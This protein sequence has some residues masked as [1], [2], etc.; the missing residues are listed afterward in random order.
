MLRKR[1]I[2][3]AVL[4]GLLIFCLTG[5]TTRYDRQDIGDYVKETIGLSEIAISETYRAQKGE[6]TYTDK[7][8][9]VKD[10]DSGLVFHVIDD[11]YWGMETMRNRLVSDYN[12]SVVHFL[13][14]QLPDCTRLSFVLSSKN[15]IFEAE[16]NGTFTNEEELQICF[17]ELEY[18]Q[19]FF[20]D[21]GYP[22]LSVTY[23]LLYDHPLNAQISDYRIQGD[24]FGKTGEIL[25]FDKMFEEYLVSVLD[26]RY[27]DAVN[28][29]PA[30]KTEAF[31]ADCTHKVGICRADGSWTYYGDLIASPYNYGISFGTLYEI[32]LREG[33]APQ[34]T[35][36]HYRF[37]GIDGSLYEISY[38]FCD[39]L[40][41]Q[42]DG[43]IENGYYYLK[44][45]ETIPMDY[46]F[47]N[48]LEV[49]Q[50][51]EMTGLQLTDSSPVL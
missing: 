46:Y 15:G 13:K 26:F 36:R 43:T 25:D 20:S 47:Y 7:I 34:G 3:T 41:E 23:Q 27:D 32:L 5:C 31:L 50:I 6:D 38:D 39:Y 40:F 42:S 11:F 1:K 51:Q 12:E 22:G 9:T 8:W 14:K 2:L 28:S 30:E 29:L 48:H 4:S 21:A 16:V 44:N 24:S 33:F 19:S 10:R 35:P 17:E 18:V 49:A 45:E 37:T